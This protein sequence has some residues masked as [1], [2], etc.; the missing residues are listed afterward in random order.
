MA[1]LIVY[2]A[3]LGMLVVTAAVLFTDPAPLLARVRAVWSATHVDLL[4]LPLGRPLHERFDYPDGQEGAYVIHVEMRA[5]SG[6]VAGLADAAE[7]A[8]RI[9]AE[10]RQSGAA[11]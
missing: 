3:L 6:I 7:T 8:A 2:A 5:W 1:D 11:R 9:E 10:H 4:G